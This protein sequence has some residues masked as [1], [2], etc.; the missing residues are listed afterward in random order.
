MFVG[1]KMGFL[2]CKS[3]RAGAPGG[4]TGRLSGLALALL[5][6]NVLAAIWSQ[7]ALADACSPEPTT[8]TVTAAPNPA[9]PG[10]SVTLTASIQRSVNTACNP[11]GTV[12]FEDGLTPLGSTSATA[13]TPGNASAQIVVSFATPG[14]H[15]IT[16]LYGGDFPGNLPSSGTTVLLIGS[17]SGVPTDSLNLRN[18][19]TVATPEGALNSANA[20]IDAVEGQIFTA[21]GDDTS[22][23]PQ[24]NPFPPSLPPYPSSGIPSP[25][26]SG[27]P[28]FA[29]PPPS[30][31]SSGEADDLAKKIAADDR[32]LDLVKQILKLEHDQKDKNRTGDLA[33]LVKELADA[34]RDAGLPRFNL[35]REPSAA[36]LRKILLDAE[37]ALAANERKLRALGGH[38]E[39]PDT[40]S[41]ISSA[42]ASIDDSSFPYVMPAPARDPAVPDDDS[43][44]LGLAYAPMVKAEAKPAKAPIVA[45]DWFGWTNMAGSGDRMG[46][47][48]GGLNGTQLNATAGLTHLLSRDVLVGVLG[49]YEYERYALSSTNSR[50]TG[51]G[52]T[53]GGYAAVRLTPTLRADGTLAWT[54][55]A[56]DGSSGAATGSFRGNRWFSGGG[57]TGVYGLG[58]GYILEPSA[59][60]FGVWERQTA[61]VDSLGTAQP[62]NSFSVGRASAGGQVY[63]VIALGTSGTVTPSLGLF[64]DYRFSSNNNGTP[65]TVPMIS[66]KDGFTARLTSGLSWHTPIGPIVGI[67]GEVGGFGPNQETLWMATGRV[68]VPF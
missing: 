43:G 53:I 12:T 25:I 4:G 37:Q 50:V 60:I 20:I 1:G 54:D 58:G 47:D 35:G 14:S 9:N 8:T 68:T 51:N 2:K 17:S 40:D 41:R 66:I 52:G 31:A 61:Y 19:Q 24:P 38:G 65:L 63:R 57:L 23:P 33:K 62:G 3:R 13:T 30:T 39:I 42:F 15:T 21:F 29:S 44:S 32:V 18:L 5:A 48:T 36:V 28:P 67:N 59:R 6:T 55:I 7:S 27:P 10:Q 46:A 49:G 64:A 56:Y 11:V 34:L 22:P 16:A 45:R 26:V